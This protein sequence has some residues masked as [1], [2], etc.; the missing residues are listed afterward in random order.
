MSFKIT[1]E[2]VRSVNTVK[3]RWQSVPRCWSHNTHYN[4]SSSLTV[5]DIHVVL[6]SLEFSA[7]PGQFADV[8]L[9]LR[10]AGAI[11]LN[12]SLESQSFADLFEITPAQC[13]IEPGGSA[14]VCIRFHAPANPADAVYKRSVD[15]WFCGICWGIT[16]FCLTVATLNLMIDTS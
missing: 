1:F 11:V 3:I 4:Y 7:P 10:N 2:G 14:E 6:Q 13:Q 15:T 8:V 5:R 16:D 12:V 9:P